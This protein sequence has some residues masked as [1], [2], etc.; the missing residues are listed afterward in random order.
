MIK[1]NETRTIE[2]RK[3]WILENNAQ[4]ITS[5]DIETFLFGEL[6]RG[7]ISTEENDSLSRARGVKS[8]F[9]NS[10][11][12]KGVDVSPKDAVIFAGEIE[13]AMEY[14]KT[15]ELNGNDFQMILLYHK[16]KIKKS[17]LEVEDSS[18]LDEKEYPKRIKL[19]NGT[20]RCLSPRPSDE[21]DSYEQDHGYFIP[22]DASDALAGIILIGNDLEYMCN[23]VNSY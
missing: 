10:V 14:G 3:I 18:S 8:K 2:N 12:N 9:F 19:S 15:G 22:G 1:R 11:M 21:Y 17:Y 5:E 23:V 6:T 7:N 4:W 16:D 20:L 13:K